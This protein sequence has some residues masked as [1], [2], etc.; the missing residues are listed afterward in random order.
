VTLALAERGFEA[1]G[2]DHSPDMLEIARRKAQ[3]AGF[4]GR[5]R[6]ETGDVRQTRFDDGE[7]GIVTCQGLLHHLEDFKP[8][9]AELERVLAP[10]GRFYI[11][12]PC[13][14]QTIAKRFLQ[15]VWRM[16]KRRRDEPVETEA[17]TVEE[18][19]SSVELRRALERLGLE[20]EVEHLTELPPLRRRLP[21]GLYLLVA[22]AVSLPW[23]RR[24]GDLIFVYGRKAS[25]KPS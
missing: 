11:S 6:F 18:P 20:H 8:C 16:G 2:I 13:R 5:C 19:I 21:D 9:L 12:D 17:E 25:V 14:E 22:K 4:A 24:K 7:F 15:A 23:R 3:E 1:I 10:G